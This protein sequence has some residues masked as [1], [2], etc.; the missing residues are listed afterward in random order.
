MSDEIAPP[1]DRQRTPN[2]LGRIK[3]AKILLRQLGKLE[4]ETRPSDGAVSAADKDLKAYQAVKA[5][6]ELARTVAGWAMYHQLGLAMAE[7]EFVPRQPMGNRDNL[8]YLKLLAAVNTHDHERNGANCR[9][10]DLA[11]NPELQRRALINLLSVMNAGARSPVLAPAVQALRGLDYGDVAP[12]LAPKLE[13]KK[14]GRAALLLQLKAIGFVTFHS[15]T[16]MTK[17]AAQEMVAAG[18]GLSKDGLRNWEGRLRKPSSGIGALQVDHTIT[19]AK[20][21]AS[22]VLAA[23]REP[24]HETEAADYREAYGMAEIRKAGAAYRA[25]GVKD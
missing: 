10:S 11:A 20:N 22:W 18:Y 2:Q 5:A 21:A 17:Q 3:R 9:E 4:R 19:L 25:C 13:H 8:E 6:M 1:P 15:E 7:L 12:M 23:L 16:G 24:E 14:A